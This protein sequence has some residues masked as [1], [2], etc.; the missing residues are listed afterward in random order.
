MNR[1]RRLDA[2][3]A[4]WL[5]RTIVRLVATYGIAIG[6]LILIGGRERFA[7]LSYRAALDTPGA[8]SSWG[9]AIILT[10]AVLLL[11]SLLGRA[12]LISYGALGGC[13][14]ALLFAYS[15]ARAALLYD[16]AGLTAPM[17]YGL[18]C[19]VFGLIA[20]VHLAMRKG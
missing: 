9:I 16:R 10:S 17:T 2:G 6:V 18:L 5:V 14:W 8:P 19:I 4:Q 3:L 15:F 12:S 7:G 1:H 13:A 11:G 20:G